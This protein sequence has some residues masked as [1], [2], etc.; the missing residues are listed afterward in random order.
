METLARG[1][2]LAARGTA[3]LLLALLCSACTFHSTDSTEV[4]VL[5]RKVT[6]F[7]LLGHQGI[8]E[9]TYPPGATYTFPALITDWNV[10]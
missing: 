1:L 10:F 3:P 6:L 7:G 8:Q 5:T 9:E 4:G 2:R